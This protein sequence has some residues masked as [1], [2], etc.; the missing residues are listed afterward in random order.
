M[1]N[2]VAKTIE[3]I[4]KLFLRH[5]D[6]VQTGV[7]DMVRSYSLFSFDFHTYVHPDGPRHGRLICSLICYINMRYTHFISRVKSPG[8]T[9]DKL[10]SYMFL[11][12]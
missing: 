1:L 4:T 3:M 2:G 8:S 12:L 5:T 11:W 9:T 10:F 7:L 6:L